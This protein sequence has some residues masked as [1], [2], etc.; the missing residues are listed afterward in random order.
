MPP[1]HR[2]RS[3]RDPDRRVFTPLRIRR[4]E[5]AALLLVSTV[6]LIL[7]TLRPTGDTSWDLCFVCGQHAG[8]D[9]L[10][11]VLLFIPIGAGLAL[12]GVSWRNAIGIGLAI[13]IVVETLQL[14]LPLGRIASISDIVTNAAGTALGFW[15]AERR[16][17]I[18]YPR[19]ATALRF[20]AMVSVGWLML[21][22]ATAVALLPSISDGAHAAK[23]SPD[24]RRLDRFMGDVL[25]AHIADVAL[26]N[27]PVGKRAALMAALRGGASVEATI[28]PGGAPPRLAPILRLINEDS[29][30]VFL[31][32]QRRADLVFRSRVLGSALRLV[33]PTVALPE[34]FMALDPDRRAMT[35]RGQRERGRLRV[36]TA[37]IDAELALHSGMGWLLFVPPASALQRSPEIVSAAWVGIPLLAPAYW[38]GRR[39][40]RR[41]RRAGDAMRMRGAGGQI[42]R[43]L[44]LLFGLAAIGLSGISALLG[45]HQPP[46]TVWIGAVIGIGT[47]LAIGASLALAHDERPHGSSRGE[48][49]TGDGS[50]RATQ[51]ANA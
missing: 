38:A 15:I 46:W 12:L 9:L 45:F 50:Q 20:A 25:D 31:L 26:P 23:W 18:A 13:T 7:V 14:A 11:N 24:V 44:P 32:G 8:V 36:G 34:A 30:E 22:T 3:P 51:T 27:G 40:R 17:A 29:T 16:R 35:I 49:T 6:T 42:L 48:S 19:S 28:R 2:H 41:A 33:T 39:A 43:A 1:T 47:G 37:D 5:G 4:I 21:L 10:A